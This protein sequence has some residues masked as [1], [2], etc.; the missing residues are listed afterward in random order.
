MPV[1]SRESLSTGGA[2]PEEGDTVWAKP[3]TVT[4]RREARFKNPYSWGADYIFVR[5]ISDLPTEQFSSGEEG[6]VDKEEPVFL[7]IT[8]LKGGRIEAQ[9]VETDIDDSE[10]S[11]IEKSEREERI[12]WSGTPQK[13]G[14]GGA[15]KR[16]RIQKEDDIRG[17][18]NDLL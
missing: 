12:E 8:S 17:D 7:Q 5:D 18:K 16:K 2:S 13:S 9:P 15:D 11:V 14:S 10:D 1:N 3:R 6:F 4:S